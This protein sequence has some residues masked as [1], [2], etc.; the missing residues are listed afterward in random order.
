MKTR[1]ITEGGM[2]HYQTVFGPCATRSNELTLA[3]HE[4]NH[5]QLI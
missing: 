3:I 5:T 2:V 4:L 1:L